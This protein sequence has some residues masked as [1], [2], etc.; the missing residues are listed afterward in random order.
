[1]FTRRRYERYRL[2]GSALA[3][4]EQPR[5]F[6]IGKP[7]P[8]E[9]GPLS[10]ISLK[11]LSVEF[12]VNRKYP[13]DHHELS[14]LVPEHGIMVYRIPFRNISDMVVSECASKRVIMRRGVQFRE[15]NHDHTERLNRLIQLYTRETVPDRRS[16]FERREANRSIAGLDRRNGLQQDRRKSIQRGTSKSGGEDGGP[17][18]SAK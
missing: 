12:V 9:L 16:G 7:K 8:I 11:G 5:I 10:D 14:I 18:F 3:V 6:N 17:F 2:M 13:G 15:L 4:Y 1:M